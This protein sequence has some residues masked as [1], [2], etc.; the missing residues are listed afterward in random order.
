MAGGKKKKKTTAGRKVRMTQ[1]EIDIYIN[2]QTIRMPDE[3]FPI[4]SKERLACTD[5]SDKGDLPVTM[6]QIDDYVAKIFREINQIEDQF[7][8]H[9]DGILNQYY[10]KGTRCERPPTTTMMMNKKKKKKHLLADAQ[11]EDAGDEQA[12]APN[13]GR[14]R[15][16]PGVSIKAG[17]VN[18]LN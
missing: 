1:E 4:V 12:R 5:L 10:R 14:R 3:I 17:K 8:K 7:M 9:R 2:Y 16:R 13:P 11:E 6:D 18:K 15:F